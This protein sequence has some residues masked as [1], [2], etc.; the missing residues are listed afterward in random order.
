MSF[1]DESL[2]HVVL[3]L[4]ETVMQSTLPEISGLAS[5]HI[6]SDMAVKSGVLEITIFGYSIPSPFLSLYPLKH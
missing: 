5:S 4:T 3:A 6:L 1:I 2:L